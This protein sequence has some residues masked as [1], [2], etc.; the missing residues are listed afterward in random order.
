MM[1]LVL[2]GGWIH[3]EGGKVVLLDERCLV[4][5]SHTL[6]SYDFFP[7]DLMGKQRILVLREMGK[8][9]CFYRYFPKVYMNWSCPALIEV[10]IFLQLQ[11]SFQFLYCL[12]V[13]PEILFPINSLTNNEDRRSQSGYVSVCCNT[14][15]IN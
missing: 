10:S 9:I 8:T 7:S 1:A 12:F 13:L 15:K 3:E 11:F 5:E 4:Y 14:M 2:G 6:D